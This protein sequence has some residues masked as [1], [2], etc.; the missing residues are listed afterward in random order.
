[1]H[2]FGESLISGLKGTNLQ[3]FVVE[4]LHEAALQLYFLAV[5]Q[6]LVK[7]P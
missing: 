1:M 6:H 5:A 2:K 7:N 3:G 4:K